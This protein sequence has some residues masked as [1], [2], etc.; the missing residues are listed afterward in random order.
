MGNKRFKMKGILVEPTGAFVVTL[1]SPE[2][3]D[4]VDLVISQDEAVKLCALFQQTFLDGLPTRT[5]SPLYPPLTL[6][7]ANLA[8]G[9]V[10]GVLVRTVEIGSV[11]LSF[12]PSLAGKLKHEIDRCVAS[13]EARA[14]PKN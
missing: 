10:P 12:D 8:E 9:Q 11:V 4:D 3:P 5:I 1:S 6:V 7:D 2:N 14:K 13:T